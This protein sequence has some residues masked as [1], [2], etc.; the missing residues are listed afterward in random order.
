[1]IVTLIHYYFV[2][3]N[4]KHYFSKEQLLSDIYLHTI[5]Y[6]SSINCNHWWTK[7]FDWIYIII[8]SLIFKKILLLYAQIKVERCRPA[9]E[10]VVQTVNRT[11]PHLLAYLSPRPLRL[12]VGA[13]WTRTWPA[14]GYSSWP[15][16][17]YRPRPIWPRL[18]SLC[19]PQ[20]QPSQPACQVTSTAQHTPWTD[21]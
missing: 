12:S 5:N 1:M 18:S 8:L 21:I 10:S 17:R 14:P 2:V 9:L 16:P 13:G 19:P 15:A 3:S 6:V 11:G 7:A 20:P 4:T